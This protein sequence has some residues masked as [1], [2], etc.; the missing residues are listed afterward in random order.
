MSALFLFFYRICSL[1]QH[2]ACKQAELHAILWMRLRPP[3][4]QGGMEKNNCCDR[5]ACY[6]SLN[7]TSN[8][9]LFCLCAAAPSSCFLIHLDS[10]GCS[11]FSFARFTGPASKWKGSA[12]LASSSV[13]HFVSCPWFPPHTPPV[14]HK[15]SPGALLLNNLCSS[16]CE[17]KLTF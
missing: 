6:E 8:L 13:E 16:V 11:G 4:N 10:A 1:L 17:F 2:C 12:R 14:E 9:Q 7:L 15:H 3:T 5:T